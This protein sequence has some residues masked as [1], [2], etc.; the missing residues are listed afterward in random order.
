M[1]ALPNLPLGRLFWKFL[2]FFFLAQTTTVLGTG[3]AIWATMPAHE[4]RAPPPFTGVPP[5]ET[6]AN[7]P[8]AFAPP[9]APDGK[10]LP[11]LH[12]PG[13]KLPLVHLLCGAL[14][15]LV[16]AAL[17]AAYVARPLRRLRQALQAAAGGQ[18]APGVSAAMGRRRDELADLGRDF[19]R[20]A[21]HLAQLMEGQRRLLHDVS[22][23]LRSPLARL[24]A[25][26][27]LARQ[28]PDKFDD[29]LARLE[30]ESVRMDRLLSEL[31][32]LSRLESG[33]L[34][35][36]DE[37]VN[38]AE[39][40]ADV[41]AD[42]APEAVQAG[43]R[44]E[45]DI[46]ASGDGSVINGDAEMLHRVF[47]N[48]LRNAL[49]HAAAGSWVG[50]ALSVVGEDL[51][52]RVE[53]RGPGVPA[54][55]LARLF[56]PFYRGTQVAARTGYGLG[57]AIARRIVDN[58]NGRIDAANRAAGGLCVS[59]YLMCRAVGGE[60]SPPAGDATTPD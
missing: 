16:F 29:C 27:G 1:P 34:A 37:R 30:H 13:P 54:T 40:L 60:G 7:G 35:R 38:V 9:P 41:I 49:T 55:E 25:V 39:L 52:V 15:S 23:E 11:P 56:E 19:D 18:L 24:N 59:V 3:L 5:G 26:I 45:L 17:L 44:V 58:H 4:T 57:L 6:A 47:D 2:I 31:L 48:L 10:P 14:V 21:Q 33:V 28:Q 42:A 51:C 53:D 50:I 20:M 43:C 22:H 12:R 8:G 46:G 32:T 36:A